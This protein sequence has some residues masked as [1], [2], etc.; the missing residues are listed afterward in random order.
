VEIQSVPLGK[1]LLDIFLGSEILTYNELEYHF[2]VLVQLH[3]ID[4]W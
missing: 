1:S 2:F 4:T 3:F